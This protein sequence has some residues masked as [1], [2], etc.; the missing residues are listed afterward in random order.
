M[1]QKKFSLPSFAKINW[2]LRVLGKRDD[3]F[4]ELCTVFQTISLKDKIFF[5]EHDD[6]CLTCNQEII[7]TDESNLI[8]KAANL[9]KKEFNCRKGAKIHL[10]KKIPAPGGLGGGSSNAAVA[11]FGLSRLWEIKVKFENLLK[12][13]EK[14]GSDVPFFLYGGTALGTGR[15]ERVELIEE[16]RENFLLIVTPPV[17]ISTATAFA[18]LNRANL[19]NF[20]AKSIL[21]I[22]RNEVENLN[23]RQKDLTNDFEESVFAL[24]PEVKRIK[25][26]L[27]ELG[28][29]QALLSGSGSSVFALFDKKETRQATIKALRKEK[30]DKNWR[31]FAVATVTRQEYRN[32]FQL[33]NQVV[34][35]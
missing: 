19:T 18:K 3:G 20:S 13:A 27:L 2:N 7:P 14:L 5:E 32:A 8:I 29:L 31:M 16:I 24:Y 26:K 33:C 30:K 9:L 23:V 6:L 1:T 22:C 21:K 12:I 35:D 25:E 34:S 11:L 28:A 17:K 15:G 10:E 4:H